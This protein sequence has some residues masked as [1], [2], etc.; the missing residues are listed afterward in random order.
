[1]QNV[2]L[3]SFAEEGIGLAA[4]RDLQVR[5]DGFEL[6]NKGLVHIYIC[7]FFNLWVC[8]LVRRGTWR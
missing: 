7:A 3:A 8:D 4:G 1:M 2:K 6:H 5:I